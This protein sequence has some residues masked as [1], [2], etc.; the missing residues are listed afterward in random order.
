LIGLKKGTFYFLGLKKGLKKGTFYFLKKKNVL[1]A[2][3]LS[4]TALGGA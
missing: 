4:R 1:N 2:I 3:N